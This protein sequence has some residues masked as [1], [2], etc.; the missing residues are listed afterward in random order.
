MV[1]DI[2]GGNTLHISESVDFLH[3]LNL[4]ERNVGYVAEA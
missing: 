4:G 2:D 1:K 3:R